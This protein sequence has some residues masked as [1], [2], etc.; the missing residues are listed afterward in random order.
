MAHQCDAFLEGEFNYHRHT[1]FH[2]SPAVFPAFGRIAFDFSPVGP[3]SL[4]KDLGH[5]FLLAKQWVQD[6]SNDHAFDVLSS[7]YSLFREFPL[8]PPEIQR[9]AFSE[10]EVTHLGRKTANLAAFCF[11]GLH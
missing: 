5:A 3:G 1:P 4:L 10:T 2:R 6:Y 7:L 11:I 8:F 9:P